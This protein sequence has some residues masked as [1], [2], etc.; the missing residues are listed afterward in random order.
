MDTQSKEAIDNWCSEEA[1]VRRDEVVRPLDAG[2][3]D[4][5]DRAEHLRA[6][7]RVVEVVP[8]VEERRVVV[9][10]EELVVELRVGREG[11]RCVGRQRTGEEALPQGLQLGLSRLRLVGA[12]HAA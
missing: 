6:G 8:G 3:C 2:A 9:R 11:D 1:R 12:A 10:A 4:G 5:A 7:G